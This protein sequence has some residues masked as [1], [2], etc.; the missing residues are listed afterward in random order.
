MLIVSH[1]LMVKMMQD[2]IDVI[3]RVRNNV[4]Y[5]TILINNRVYCVTSQRKLA[6]RFIKE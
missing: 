5:Y 6:K 3:E 4:R 1:V 2:V